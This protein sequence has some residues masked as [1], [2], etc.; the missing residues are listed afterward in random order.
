MI[1]IH[2]S[3]NPPSILFIPPTIYTLPRPTL[4]RS[5]LPRR[6]P[7]CVL[8]IHILTPLH[9]LSTPPTLPTPA[10]HHPASTT[11]PSQNA[12][13]RIWRIGSHVLRSERVGRQCLRVHQV[14]Y[15]T[16]CCSGVH[17]FCS[18]SGIWIRRSWSW[19]GTRLQ[20][21]RDGTDRTQ[22]H[23]GGYRRV[24]GADRYGWCVGG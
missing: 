24:V 7:P 5:T 19:C 12:I 23:H 2:H 22:R 4:A 16:S 9:L 15:I 3:S 21:R 1:Y 13:V 18:G 10:P 8:I 20:D 6:R 14:R 11:S 17:H